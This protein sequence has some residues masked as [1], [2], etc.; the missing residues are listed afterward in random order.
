M[1]V[2]LSGLSGIY[3]VKGCC[4]GLGYDELRAGEK[5]GEK[6]GASINPPKLREKQTIAQQYGRMDTHSGRHE[7]FPGDLERQGAL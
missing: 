1:P 5:Q 3:L 6:K 7:W 4:G 2:Q